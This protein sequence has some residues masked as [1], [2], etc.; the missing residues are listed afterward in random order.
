MENTGK[1]VKAKVVCAL[2]VAA[3]ILGALM[4]R[5]ANFSYQYAKGSVWTHEPLVAPFDFPILKT[6]SQLAD[7]RA[8]ASSQVLPYFTL[9]SEV[10]QRNV[11]ALSRLRLPE[12]PPVSEILSEAAS[13]IYYK[14]II[15][16]DPS[17]SGFNGELPEAVCVQRGRS[18][19]TLPSTAIYT[20]ASAC[21]ALRSALDSCFSAQRA[22]SLLSASGA[23][24]CIEPNLFYDSRTTSL[25]RSDAVDN[26]PTTCGYVRSGQVIVSTGDMVT[27]DTLQL[28]E[29]FKAEY[30]AN[31]AY[32][33][34]MIFQWLGN[35]IIAILM[36]TVLFFA[37]YYTNPAVFSDNRFWYL[38]FVFTLTAAIALFTQRH[39]PRYI[40]A[41]PFT[42]AALYLQAFFREKLIFAVYMVCLLPLLVFARS[43]VTLFV[44]YLFA[45]AVSLYSFRFFNRKWKQFIS[46]LITFAALSLSWG[47]FWLADLVEG[48]FLRIGSEFFVSAMLTVMGYPLIYLFEKL[49]NLVSNSRLRDLTDSSNPLLREL[50]LKAPGTFHHCVQV[51]NMAETAARSIGAN[52]LLVKAGAM[53]HDIGKMRNPQC[54]I[55]NE[56]LVN[57]APEQKYHYGLSPLQSSRDI[58]RHV[59]DGMEI[60][61]EYSLPQLVSDFIITHHGTTVTRFFYEKFLSEG[62]DP[63][64]K[65]SFRYPGL[66]PRTKEQVILML[67]DTIEAASRTLAAS[68]PEE[69]SAFVEEMVEGKMQ[70]GQFT[71][72]EISIKDMETV[73]GVIKSYLS[74]VYHERVAYPKT[75]SN[76]NKQL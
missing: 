8:S 20:R 4:P 1:S 40:F 13:K 73:K 31:V 37:I 15:S 58:I 56:S 23:Y 65:D 35:F 60:A 45:G 33:G 55:E 16:D 50:E 66:A 68:G 53:Y 38:L 3:L 51:M 27:E 10:G 72:S 74:Q 21:E 2:A 18:V 26:V 49:F 22:D 75:K 30:E 43:G 70:E 71:S 47:G 59:S 76:S 42:L 52:S 32:S 63:A 64:E 57:K 34:P 11:A 12:E 54:F 48:S 28:L 19:E 36:V 17:L 25:V 67:C 9:S 14:G 41:V 7:D 46:A 44:I 39:Y 61:R 24:G 6:S 62:G 5:S 69:Y 29:S